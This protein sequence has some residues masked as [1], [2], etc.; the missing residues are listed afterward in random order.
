MVV[1]RF[2][3]TRRGG[4]GGQGA[5]NDRE[6]GL[7]R[8]SSENRVPGN[9]SFLSTGNCAPE[10]FGEPECIGSRANGGASRA[11]PRRQRSCN[12]TRAS[13]GATTERAN[14]IRR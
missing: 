11:G 13:A 14:G 12:E 4:R 9:R 3:R 10:S 5:I 1:A 6:R 2:R 8:D 7:Q